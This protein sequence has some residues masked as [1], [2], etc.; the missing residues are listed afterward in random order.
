VET[1]KERA[2]KRWFSVLAIV[3][4]VVMALVALNAKNKR[5]SEPDAG[6]RQ[7]EV[8]T[9]TANPSDHLG[10]VLV[11]GVVGGVDARRSVVLLVDRAEAKE[12][13][14]KCE[15][16]PGKQVPL[17]WTGA[18]PKVGSEILVSGR[19]ARRPEGL[20][21]TGIYAG[22]PT[23]LGTPGEQ[24]GRQGSAGRP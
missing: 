1:D 19:L 21:L 16:E 24:H 13:G 17:R 9:L 12:C 4:L 20:V 8:T 2:M 5:T 15:D 3:A 14:L 7:L 22:K 10:S 18:L 6:A 11:A 23:P